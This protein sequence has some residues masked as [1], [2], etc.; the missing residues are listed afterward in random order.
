MLDPWKS[1]LRAYHSRPQLLEGIVLIYQWKSELFDVFTSPWRSWLKGR[2]LAGTS[3][4]C[5]TTPELHIEVVAFGL[6]DNLVKFHPWV[7][8]CIP[9][10]E[11]T[12]FHLRFL[13]T[14]LL[15][16][17][18]VWKSIMGLGIWI[19]WRSCLWPNLGMC[20]CPFY[21]FSDHHRGVVNLAAW[22]NSIT[23]WLYCSPNF[24]DHLSSIETNL[25]I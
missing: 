19:P 22:S 6:L 21:D 11:I 24:W 9:P 15:W 18:A 5:G 7:S 3:M 13:R 4:P 23:D 2:R 10:H 8:D 14:L 12:S 25:Q 20:F 17:F 16:V 1:D